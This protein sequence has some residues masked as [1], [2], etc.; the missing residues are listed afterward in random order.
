MAIVME[1]LDGIVLSWNAAA[2][3]LFGYCAED[4]VGRRL[5][6]LILTSDS[7][8]EDSDRLDRCAGGLRVAPFDTIRRR[9]DGT[10]VE[11][12]ITANPVIGPTGRVV[13]VAKTIRDNQRAPRRPRAKYFLEQAG[14]HIRGRRLSRIDLQSGRQVWTRQTFKIYEVEGDVAPSAE[15]FDR[16]MAPDVGAR[17][18]QAIRDASETGTGYDIEIPAQTARGRPIWIRTIGVVEF[19]EGKPVRVVGAT[20]DITER[21]TCGMRRWSKASQNFARCSSFPSPSASP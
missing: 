20:Q 15:E 21:K 16:L 14:A 2:T 12:S 1:S 3:K 13:A 18:W 9:Q 17:L 19:D 4:A 10:H 6:D 5:I 11:V 7:V 8:Y